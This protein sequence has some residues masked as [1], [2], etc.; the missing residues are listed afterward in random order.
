[1]TG[2]ITDPGFD[3]NRIEEYKLSI[4]VSLDGFSFSVVNANQKKLLALGKTP[5][6]LSSN[7]FLGRRFKEWVQGNE[8]LQKKYNDVR[9]IFH[10]ENFTFTP[11]EYYDSG[12]LETYGNLVLGNSE[13]NIFADNYLPNAS[14]NLIFPVSLNLSGELEQLF[15]GRKPLHPLTI[16]NAELQKLTDLKN[17][18]MALYFSKKSFSLILF[19]NSQLKVINSYNYTNSGDV[20]YYALASVKKLKIVP[21]KTALFM[22]G[23]IMPKGEIHNSLRKFFSRAVFFNPEIHYN[24]EIFKEPL[25]QFIVLF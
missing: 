8:I 22:A 3:L 4:Q 17:G 18:S 20:I 23:E 13:G 16:L 2:L 25:H 12:N 5:I 19:S 14:G 6:E 7:K 10:S 9:I 1:M 21:E 11:S 15:P 24:S